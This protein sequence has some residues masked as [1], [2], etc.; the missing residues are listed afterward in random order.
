MGRSRPLAL[1]ALAACALAGAQEQPQLAWE[2]VVDGTSVL[3]IR[4]NRVQIEDREGL[5]VQRQRFRFFERLPD[6]RQTVRMEVREGR[7]RVRIVQQPRLENNYVLAVSIEDHQGGASFYSLEF[8]WDTGRGGFFSAPP[9]P[10][11]SSSDGGDRV[12]WSGRVD[13]EA[14][15]EC[16]G[17]E[18]RSRA[19]TGEPV[20]RE[21]FRF[22]RPLP[23]RDVTVSLMEAQG[24]GEV[25]LLQQPRQ[26]NGY[27]ALVR[28]RDSRG[29]AGDYSFTLAWVPPPRFGGG[30]AI[31]R[32]GMVWFGRVDGR[33]RV[34]VQGS[35]ARS[36]V[37]RGQ[38]LEAERSE[39]VRE[40]PRR[41]STSATVRRV[42]GRGRVELVEF[43]TRVNGYKLVFQIDDSQGGAGDY[44]IEVAW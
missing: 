37:V 22:T 25:V 32:R 42:R 2:G 28:I 13:D 36:E 5:P 15:V 9:D 43:P 24:R 23:N 20:V 39:F 30:D 29:G 17:R 4:G 11:T 34:T 21:R 3:S 35:S 41:D 27:T 8:F 19:V 31:A 44:E 14:I 18:C 33:V 40:L 1:L 12:A 38:P 16:R 7:G 26:E 10:R 6:S